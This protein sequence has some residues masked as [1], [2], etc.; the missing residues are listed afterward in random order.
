MT[1]SYI[2]ELHLTKTFEIRI[3]EI[4]TKL[5]LL[6][7]SLY[8]LRAGDKG[9]KNLDLLELVLVPTETL[10]F[11]LSRGALTTESNVLFNSKLVAKTEVKLGQKPKLSSLKNAVARS[12]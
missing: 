4:S 3:G 11:G 6:F 1:F 2:S 10:F 7:P 9:K 12:G 8:P 5:T